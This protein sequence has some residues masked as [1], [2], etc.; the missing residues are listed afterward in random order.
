MADDV[1][2][3]KAKANAIGPKTMEPYGDWQN[4]CGQ[5]PP[6]HCSGKKAL[7]GTVNKRLLFFELVIRRGGR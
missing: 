7:R 6:G 1:R 3:A 5:N 4:G 2:K